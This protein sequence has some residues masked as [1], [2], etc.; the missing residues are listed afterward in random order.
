MNSPQIEVTQAT[1]MSQLTQL[2]S[3]SNTRR[4]QEV[5][6]QRHEIGTT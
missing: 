1:Q 3:K 4:Y 2:A 5:Q 6:A